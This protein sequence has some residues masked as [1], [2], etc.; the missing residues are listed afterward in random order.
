MTLVG[1]TTLVP[2]LFVELGVTV[3][4]DFDSVL[5][6]AD[7][8]ML[9]R[10]QH[11]RQRRS[12]FPSVGEYVSLFGLNLNRFKRCKPECSSCIPARSIAASRSPASCRRP[13]LDRPSTRCR[14]ASPSAWRCFICSVESNFKVRRPWIAATFI[15][16]PP[17]LRAYAV[18]RE[19]LSPTAAFYVHRGGAAR[20]REFVT[21]LRTEWRQAREEFSLAPETIYF[22]GGTPSIL[23]AELFAEL[24]E[25]VKATGPAKKT[26]FTLEV[27]PATVTDEKAAAWRAAGVNRISLGAQSFD[28]KMLKI[29]GRQ[30][31]PEEIAE[32]CSLLRQHG[33][34]NI[35]ID[36]MFALPGQSEAK[37][38]ETLVA[39]LACKPKHV[40]AYALTYEED[41][42]FFEKLRRGEWRQDE[43]REIAMFE[44][45]RSVLGA[46]GFIDYEISNFALPGFESRHNLG[47]WRGEDYLGLGPS[48]C[49]TIGALRWKN[50]PDTQTYAERIARGESVRMEQ[51][52]LDAAT[53]ARERIMFGL[54]MREG[55]ALGEFSPQAQAVQLKDLE[56]DGLAVRE[57]QRVCLTARGKLV[58]DS[59]AGMFV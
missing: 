42:P 30:H 49:S 41:T 59:V 46:A 6:D 37:W 56:T 26:E 24:A 17:P 35:N 39:A 53:R 16:D 43:T 33:F 12:F 52:K 22:G 8:I 21:A 48:A 3:E 38:E 58:A 51:E 5:P 15:H 44:R 2:E 9:L 32:T 1:P 18:L 40:S 20:Q 47:Y 29:L 11:E 36:L 14:T 27:N 19:D 25:E 54:R 57:G 4:H 13:E 55:V 10:I 34:E 45:T 31:A 7:V 28:G 50:V 23:S